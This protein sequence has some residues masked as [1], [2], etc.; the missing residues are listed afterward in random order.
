LSETARRAFLVFAICAA[1][2]LAALVI[3]PDA[4]PTNYD[5]LATGLLATGGFGFD[6]T[7]STYIEP[8]YPAF[9]A[10]VRLVTGHSLT[11][12]LML[13]IV[14][15]SIGGVLLDRLASHHAGPRAG[16]LAAVFYAVNPYLVRQSVALLE[17]T[18]CTTLA[19]AT[20]LALSRTDRIRGA[21]ATGALFGLLVLTRTSFA[22][23]AIGAAAWLAW[24]PSTGL[25]AG[26][27]T[28]LATAM[29]LTALLVETPWLVRNAGI[30]GSPL[31]SRVGENLYLSTSIYGSVVPVH[32]I[33][34]LV[35]LGL[36]DVGPGVER[37]GLPASLQGRALD[38]AML[39]RGLA[40]MREHPGRVLWLKLRNALYLFTPR[41]LPRDAKSPE[42]MARREGDTV[43]VSAPRRPWIM[44]TVHTVAQSVLLVLAAI[45]IARRGVPGTDAPLLILLAAQ[46]LVCVAFF[47]TTRLMA[48]VMFVLMFYA[49]TGLTGSS[50][51]AP[52]RR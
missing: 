18:L 24:R 15:A 29:L 52:R 3:F 14:V 5:E 16:F 41:L 28:R 27:S 21:L 20:A 45:G 33:D 46:A 2:R 38:D 42:A 34:L 10:A 39:R 19:I 35:P 17:I 47:P 30:D 50:A 22:V 48:P 4:R 26:P 7:P 25:G 6:G 12:V 49:A 43:I 8:L 32:D 11:L 1:P 23:A 37:L 40:F 13:Q 36:A 51:A 31:P 44:D 9:L